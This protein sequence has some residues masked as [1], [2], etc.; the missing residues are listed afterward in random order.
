MV[1]HRRIQALLLKQEST[2]G[3][4]ETPSPTA[5]ALALAGP[6]SFK[7]NADVQDSD[8]ITGGLDEAEFHMGRISGQLQFPLHLKGSGTG[9]EAPQAGLPLKLCGMAET[10]LAAAVPASGTSTA[11]GGTTN[12]FTIDTASETD[13]STTDDEYVGMPVT[14]AG[15]PATALTTIITG[16]KVA[17][18]IATVTVAHTFGTALDSSTTAKIEANAVYMPAS[19]S[20]PHATAYGYEDGVLDKLIG[21]LGT[22]SLQATVGQ[23]GMLDVTLTGEAL[24]QSDAA[25]PTTTVEATR[26]PVW[27]N[28]VA[29]LNGA[30]VGMNTFSVNPNNTVVQPDDPN[31]A[32]GYDVPTIVSPRRI[33]GQVDPNRRLVATSAIVAAFVNGT[34]GVIHVQAGQSAGNKWAVTV[35]Q[36]KYRGVESGDRNGISMQNIPFSA[37][38][39]DDGVFITFW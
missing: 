14:L 10:L 38:G 18:G 37:L 29:L 30:A 16:Y 39:S 9:G 26:P 32:E 23:P 35:R 5:N 24:D 36:A 12:S 25:V 11:T 1:M 8:E 22:F 34:T 19:A 2:P 27:K 13:W 20:I 3:T 15:N 7:R 4:E 33:Q 17:A 21:A 6:F 31:G 28:G